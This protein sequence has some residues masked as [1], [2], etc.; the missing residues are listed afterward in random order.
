MTKQIKLF[1]VA[2]IAA[3]FSALSSEAQN[4]INPS[5]KQGFTSQIE[6]GALIHEGFVGEYANISSGYNMLPGLF[7]GIGVGIKNQSF[8]T[9]S[10]TKS[11][12]VPVYAHL[13]YS[14]LNK[15]V[16]PFVDLKGG[17]VFDFSGSIKKMPEAYPKYG[18]G[19]FFRVGIGVDYK[20]YSL[21]FGDDW[22]Q[23]S[24]NKISASW[25]DYAWV[26]GT[27]IRF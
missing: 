19:H 25:N 21:Y 22:A 5:Y 8:N 2:F 4:I 3:L 7:T 27:A 14:F 15:T 1:T 6:A 20:R 26:I 17:M 9:P 16:S 10:S 18:C 13:K 23:L 11:V 12:H 24:Y